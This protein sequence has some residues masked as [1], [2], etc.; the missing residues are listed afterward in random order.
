MTSNEIINMVEGVNKVQIESEHFTESESNFKN[1]TDKLLDIY[2]KKN[3][4]YGDAFTESMDEFGPISAA[5]RM[6]DKL[7]RFKS[8]INNND[9]LVKDESIAD[10]VLDLANYAIMTYMW[11]NKD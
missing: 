10:T 6:N 2:R 11:L 5:I 1:V 3:H 4:D 9:A 7:K 8:L